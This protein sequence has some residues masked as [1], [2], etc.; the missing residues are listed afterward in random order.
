MPP[1]NFI[2]V[3]KFFIKVL[4]TVVHIMLNYISYKIIIFIE[5][6]CRK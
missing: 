6:V 1:K 2:C 3:S 4:D 5:G